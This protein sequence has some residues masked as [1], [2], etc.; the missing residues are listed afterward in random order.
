MGEGLS[1]HVVPRVGASAAAASLR[2]ARE[3]EPWPQV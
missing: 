3:G 2:A 1:D